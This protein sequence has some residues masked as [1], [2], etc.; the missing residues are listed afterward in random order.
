MSKEVEQVKEFKNVSL[1]LLGNT[2]DADHQPS[3]G[4]LRVWWIPQIPGTPFFVQVA[5]PE[6]AKKVLNI[7]AFYDLFQLANRIKPDYS[8][9]GGLCVF[10]PADIQDGDVDSGWTEWY[11][12]AGDCI[13]EWEPV[14][15]E[16]NHA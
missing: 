1:D 11:S 2:L 12:E 14:Q 7:L 16:A 5:S 6:E 13:D 8:N 3:K 4:S 10:D 9:V 15:A